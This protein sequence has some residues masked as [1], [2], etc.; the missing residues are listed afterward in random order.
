MEKNKCSMCHGYGLWSIGDASPMGRM[1][2]EDGCPSKKC[3]ECGKG[4]K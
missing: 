4:G 1:D 2:Y 3:P